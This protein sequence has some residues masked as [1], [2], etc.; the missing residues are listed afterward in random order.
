VQDTTNL[1]PCVGDIPTWSRNCAHPAAAARA[2]VLRRLVG[3]QVSIRNL[4]DILESALGA[5]QRDKEVA[6]LTEFCAHRL[7]AP[8][9]TALHR[10]E[11]RAVYAAARTR[12]LLRQACA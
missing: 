7:A 6:S 12:D 4:R 3:E 1:L 2:E 10:R 5:S 9:A 8:S 11:M